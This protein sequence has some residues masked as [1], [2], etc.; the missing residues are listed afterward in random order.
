MAKQFCLG[1][2]VESEYIEGGLGYMLNVRTP[3]GF[4]GAP[5]THPQFSHWVAELTAAVREAGDEPYNPDSYTKRVAI[6][7]LMHDIHRINQK[8]GF[9]VE[10]DDSMPAV[11]IQSSNPYD[12]RIDIGF[13]EQAGRFR[14]QERVAED[15]NADL[16]I[17][18]DGNI[19]VLSAE[20]REFP[21]AETRPPS[22]RHKRGNSPRF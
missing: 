12:F 8:Y 20:T 10:S 18:K 6:A 2:E 22:R 4:D 17:V 3:D 15:R 5:Q 21:F 7:E 1:I 11:Q 16:Q 13:S 14:V 19:H 9:T